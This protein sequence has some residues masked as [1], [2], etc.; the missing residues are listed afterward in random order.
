ML[1]TVTTF[2]FFSQTAEYAVTAREFNNAAKQYCGIGTVEISPPNDSL[3]GSDYYLDA[4]PRIAQF[5]AEEKR[6]YFLI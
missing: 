5:L 2:A 4:D 3:P 6:S 1:L